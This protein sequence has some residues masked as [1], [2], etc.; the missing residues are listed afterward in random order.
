[1]QLL[2]GG[3]KPKCAVTSNKIPTCGIKYYQIIVKLLFIVN[4]VIESNRVLDSGFYY[5]N[6]SPI[7]ENLIT[8]EAPT[9]QK[10]LCL[11]KTLRNIENIDLH[12]PKYFLLLKLKLKENYYLETKNIYIY[13]IFQFQ[14]VCV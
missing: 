7:V 2:L 10:C 8:P 5:C 4:Q 3:H 9:F 14:T 1:M 13:I 6:T 12:Y 11:L